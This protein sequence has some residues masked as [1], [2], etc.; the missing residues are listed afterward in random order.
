MRASRW[1]RRR[2]PAISPIMCPRPRN[3]RS[4]RAEPSMNDPLPPRRVTDLLTARAVR[5]RCA[6]VAGE[7]IAGR[8]AYFRWH[9]ER[10]P[11]VADYVVDVIRERYP[12]L[13]VPFHSR[14]R[15]FEVGGIDRWGKLADRR[16]LRGIERAKA[17]IDLV[18]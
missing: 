10:L 5:E 6:E 2:R 1:T 4:R 14:W 15:H 18:I 9:G 11:A 17:A 7:A 8:S 12:D 13:R 16:G 3:S